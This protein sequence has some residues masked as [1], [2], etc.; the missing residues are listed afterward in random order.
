MQVAVTKSRI[1][2]NNLAQ[3]KQN[4]KK[5]LI[6]IEELKH[7]D[8]Q[9]KL[10]RTAGRMFVAGTQQEFSEDLARTVKAYEEDIKIEMD[11]KVEEMSTSIAV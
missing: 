11:I 1:F 7:L 3:L 10:Y 5:T 9:S 4:Y 6:T 8:P 2:D